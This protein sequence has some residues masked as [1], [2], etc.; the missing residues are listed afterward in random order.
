[1]RFGEWKAVRNGPS[2]KV[3]LYDLAKDAA[4]TTDVA[5]RHPDLVARAEALMAAARVDDPNWPMRDTK[6]TKPAK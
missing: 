5:A 6:K 1:V 4:E 2:A 3:E